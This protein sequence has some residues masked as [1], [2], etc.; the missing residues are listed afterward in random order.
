MKDTSASGPD[1]LV[2]DVLHGLSDGRFAPGQRLSEPD[3]M[4][5]YGVGRSTVREALSRLAAGGV[6]TLAP[7]R[8]AQIR[9]LSPQE[10]RD[11]LRVTGVLL[12]LAARQAAEAVAAGASA[13]DLVAAA[14]EYDASAGARARARYYRALTRLAGNA[15]LDRMLPSLQVHLVRAQ[16]RSL[17]GGD[18]GGR[19]GMVAAIAAA[20]PAQAEAAARSHVATILTSLAETGRES[21]DHLDRSA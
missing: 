5:L 6:V 2:R 7:H 19:S 12:G 21:G 16:V 20:D 1:A 15:E 9:R 11:V 8:G 10:V 14:Q 4:A 18:A 13:A 3:L 17:G